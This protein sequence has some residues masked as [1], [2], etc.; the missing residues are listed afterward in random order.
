MRRLHLRR[1]TGLTSPNN[2]FPS[3]TAKRYIAKRYIAK[4][5]IAKR[6]IAKRNLDKRYTA[7]C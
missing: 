6:Y 4:R 2:F 7:K 5:Y 1:D 3:Y